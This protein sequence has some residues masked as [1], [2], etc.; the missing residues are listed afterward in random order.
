MFKA[1]PSA[2]D[3][4]QKKFIESLMGIGGKKLL[5]KIVRHFKKQNKR[6]KF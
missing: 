5:K 3:L 4:H 1:K 6:S 2:K